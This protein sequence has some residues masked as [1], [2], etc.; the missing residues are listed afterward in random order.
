MNEKA[1]SYLEN[2]FLN[3]IFSKKHITD[4]SYNGKDIYYVDNLHG[5]IRYENNVSPNEVLNFLKQIANLSEQLFSY[6]T[7]IL[8]ISIGKY[9]LNAVHPLIGRKQ[10]ENVATFSLRIGSEN[11]IL[12]ENIKDFMPNEVLIYLKD[13]INKRQSII[14]SGR[15][16]SGKTELQKYLLSEMEKNTRVIIIDNVLELDQSD[17]Q[18]NKDITIWQVNNNSLVGFKDLI[19]NGLRSNP[20]WLIIAEARGKEMG[21]VLASSMSGHPVIT[22]IHSKDIYS[23][24]SRITRMVLMNDNSQKYEEVFNDVIY[25]FKHYV[26]LEKSIDEHG[27]IKRY[28]KAL[29]K[30]NENGHLDVVYDRDINDKNM[31][32]EKICTIRK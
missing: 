1:I 16:G 2:S 19:R 10:N 31:R 3:P 25:H 9:R 20:D 15:T 23:I 8:D 22:T 7:P 13:L 5:R 12:K 28:V 18:N 11:I 4:I 6:T 24:P 21:D 32:K 17:Y 30:I 27:K 29:A 14:I 26:Y